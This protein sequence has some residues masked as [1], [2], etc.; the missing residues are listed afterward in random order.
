VRGGCAGCGDGDERERK[1]R[2]SRE[3]EPRNSLEN[4][5]Q[6]LEAHGD[7]FSR[8]SSSSILS[9]SPSPPVTKLTDWGRNEGAH[10]NAGVVSAVQSSL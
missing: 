8:F 9:P 3:R 7:S 10:E 2:S 6:I 1:N 5:T 4:L